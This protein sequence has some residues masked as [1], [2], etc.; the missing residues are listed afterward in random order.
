MLSFVTEVSK[1][2]FVEIQPVVDENLNRKIDTRLEKYLNMVCF[3]KSSRQ[4]S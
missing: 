4:L 3:L 2:V 1:E